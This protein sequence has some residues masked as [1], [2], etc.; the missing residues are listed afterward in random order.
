MT[1]LPDDSNSTASYMSNAARTEAEMKV[2]LE[3]LHEVIAEIGSK[4]PTTLTISGGTISEPLSSM[5]LVGSEGGSS[6]DDVMTGM[7]VSNVTQG[8][9]VILRNA[10][11]ASS[12]SS[13]SGKVTINS[14]TGAAA[15]E[16]SGG[17]SFVLCAD[18]L[19]AVIYNGNHWVEV[20]R[21]YGRKN[22][23]DSAADRADLGLGSAALETVATSL[24]ASGS[25]ILKTGSSALSSGDVLKVDGSG[26]IIAATS[27]DLGGGNADTVDNK[28]ASDFVSSTDT[29]AQS[30]AANLTATTSGS[31]RFVANSTGTSQTV[32]LAFNSSGV[33]R[34]SI[35]VAQDDGR[36]VLKTQAAD[37]SQTPSIR[38][39]PS[40]SRLEFLE[41]GSA[42]WESLRPGPGN[43]LNAD[44]VDGYHASTLLGAL[45]L[46][47][48]NT[49]TN[50][51][52]SLKFEDPGGS[53]NMAIQYPAGMYDLAETGNYSDG[54][55]INGWVYTADQYGF[56]RW[57]TWTFGT[58][59]ESTPNLIGSFTS[60]NIQV[61]STYLRIRGYRRTGTGS[62][63]NQYQYFQYSFSGMPMVIGKV[64]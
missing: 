56:D 10:T 6:V 11:T 33:E 20:S 14:G 16:L 60:A 55:N 58:A 15:I 7:S 27:G 21:F 4:P 64:A 12:E 50:T 18:R 51:N 38:L 1:Q 36:L 32:G 63:G 2:A 34:G 41:N 57:W 45:S 25:K 8:R 47:T 9:T 5:V 39:N 17:G 59:Y 53:L 19:L 61:T 48:H 40:N 54:H 3:Q 24:G 30:M 22:A 42:S 31:T 49:G 35:Y 62:P 43:G 46:V 23:E 28:H 26:N 37:S 29:G 44:T 52:G 13:N